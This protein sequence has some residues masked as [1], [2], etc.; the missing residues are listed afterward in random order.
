M[1]FNSAMTELDWTVTRLRKDI[2]VALD[3]LK[4][5]DWLLV[6]AYLVMIKISIASYVY[7]D[8][9]SSMAGLAGLSRYQNAEKTTKPKQRPRR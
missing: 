8:G 9:F 1:T 2:S 4:A 3:W 5:L 7:H 6:F